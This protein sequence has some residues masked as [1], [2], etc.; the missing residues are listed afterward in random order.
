MAKEKQHTNGTYELV[1]GRRINVESAVRSLNVPSGPTAKKVAVDPKFLKDEKGN[2]RFARAVTIPCLP[3]G[4]SDENISDMVQQLMADLRAYDAAEEIVATIKRKDGTERE[5]RGPRTIK[6]CVNDKGEPISAGEY[7]ANCI[8]GEH[9]LGLQKKFYKANFPKALA[10][11]Y[12]GT[13]TG[14]PYEKP[15]AKPARAKRVEEGEE[16]EIAVS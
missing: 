9:V 6:L 15:P 4:A 13:L 7:I 11:A 2:Y 1:A 3:S 12:D 16:E 8:M 5:V 14:E 10:A